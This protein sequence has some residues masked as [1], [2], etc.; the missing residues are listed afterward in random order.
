MKK[1]KKQTQNRQKKQERDSVLHFNDKVIEEETLTQAMIKA[2]QIIEGK[3]KA[4]EVE[5]ENKEKKEW[6]EALGQKDFPENEKWI[7][8]KIHAARNDLFALWNILFFKSK[9]VKDM[10][11]TMLLMQLAV[12]GMFAICKW[13]LYLFSIAGI[14]SLVIG[15]VDY[16]PGLSITLVAWMFARIFRIAAFEIEKM[17]D[18]NLLIAIFSGCVSFAAMVVAVIAL[19]VN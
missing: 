12:M 3:K 15:Q 13:C 6:Q 5:L 19:F 8:K 9:N 10:R 17:K 18:G 11:T 16:I 14:Y 2:Y 4:K 1:K 7:W